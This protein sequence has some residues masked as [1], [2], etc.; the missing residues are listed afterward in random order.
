MWGRRLYAVAL[1]MA[2]APFVVSAG[3][4]A[5]GGSRYHAAFDRAIIELTVRDV[6]RHVVEVGAY[7]IGKPWHHPGPAFFYLLAVPYRLLGSRGWSLLAAALVLNGAAVLAA[8]VVAQRRGGAGLA[9]GM[10]TGLAILTHALG[11][12]FLRDPWNPFVLAL[13][14]VLLV[15]L[16]WTFAEGDAWML[17][18]AA[19]VASF[20]IQ[21]HVGTALPVI[22]L[23]VAAAVMAVM[24]R[25]TAR[26]DTRAPSWTRPMVVSSVVVFVMW[27]FPVLDAA[28]HSGGNL[29]RLFDYFTQSRSGQGLGVSIRLVA[30]Q[31]TLPPPWLRGPPL[32]APGFYG[33]PLAI[34][35]RPLPWL[36]LALV[37]ATAVAWRRGER[38]AALF[39]VL[40][41][42]VLVASVVAITRITGPVEY[43]L[44][45]Y[46]PGIAM[47]AAVATGYAA[48]TSVREATPLRRLRWPVIALAGVAIGLPASALAATST[49][50]H[51]VPLDDTSAAIDRITAASVRAA[52]RVRQPVLVRTEGAAWP[53]LATMVA[54]LAEHGISAR[55]D[56]T[57]DLPASVQ[58]RGHAVG[59]TLTI[60]PADFLAPNGVRPGALVAGQP[61]PLVLPPYLQ[62]KLASGRKLNYG[63]SLRYIALL[64]ADARQQKG[65]VVF[66]APDTSPG[67]HP[68]L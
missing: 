3:A 50:V 13:P 6:G 1:L 4:L 46:L 42:V 51:R 33:V 43:W 21:A 57:N 63:E 59:G 17:P 53:E 31:L 55:V 61:A 10:A 49:N 8:I 58:R 54:M 15:L 38:E 2:V 7:S 48:W 22:A 19:G 52:R 60:A 16:A 41:L 32:K 62:A 47:L 27:M 5:V 9:V 44:L 28:T 65:F 66:F 39:G 56:G 68:H 29:R 14:M 35:H 26:D 11:A 64:D 67:T 34:P 18:W 24:R 45:A 23:L 36:G 25:R 40:V 12:S 20:T 30:A 37:A